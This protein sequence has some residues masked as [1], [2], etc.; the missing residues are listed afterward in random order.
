MAFNSEVTT[1]AVGGDNSGED[2]ITDISI[3]DNGNIY[4]VGDTNGAFGE[5]SGGGYDAFIAKITPSYSVGWVTHFGAI[6][7]VT[8]FI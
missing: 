2:F 4:C 3:D 6:T 8:S 7:K 5:L 1:K